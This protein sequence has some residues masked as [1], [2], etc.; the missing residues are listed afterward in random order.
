MAALRCCLGGAA[1]PSASPLISVAVANIGC[2]SSRSAPLPAVVRRGEDSPSPL[3]FTSCANATLHPSL[4]LRCMLPYE[5][6]RAA[7]SNGVFLVM[8]RRPPPLLCYMHAM[9]LPR[10]TVPIVDK[11]ADGREIATHFLCF[12]SCPPPLSDTIILRNAQT[13]RRRRQQL[14]LSHINEGG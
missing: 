12:L 13:G 11:R 3:P 4:W 14:V 2:C 7:P 10:F 5:G 8:G 9:L 1:P 6:S